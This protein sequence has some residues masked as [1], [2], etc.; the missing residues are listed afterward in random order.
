M[1]A[2]TNDNSILES[3]ADLIAHL[4]TGVKPRSDW[5][6]G[7]EHEKFAFHTEDLRPLSYDEPGG[8]RDLLNQMQAFGWEPVTES[9]N[10]IGL[11]QNGA[12]ISLEPGG[13]FELSGAPLTSIHETCDE[14]SSHL[15]QVRK[16][17]EDLQ[18]GFLGMGFHPTLRREDVPIMP[19]GRYGIMRAYMPTKGDMGLDMMLRTCTVQVNL[20]FESEADM[21]EKFRIGL[22]LQPI[23]TA[24]FAS[25]PFK[26]GKPNGFS[27]LRSHAW[28]R[29]D[30]DRTGMVPFVFDDD[31]GFE[32]YVDYVLDVPMY[33][34]VRD[35]QYVNVA[36]RS[37]R[38]FLR[39]EL[40]GHIG[41]KPTLADWKDHLSTVFTEVRLKT[42]L[43]MRGADGGPWS[44]LCGLPAVLG[45]LLND[46]PAQQKASAQIAAW[47]VE[48]QEALRAEVSK[49]GLKAE[50][51][52]APLYQIAR[53]VV[54]I[55]DEGLGR[56][57][58][59]NS[60]GE[61][62][63]GFLKVLWDSVQSGDNAA[64]RM[65]ALY[66]REWGEDVRHIFRDFAY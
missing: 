35:G 19:K 62:E 6:I 17:G 61:S 26:E 39:G 59:K 36:G 13:Q 40:P 58:M 38:D 4:E 31:F 55:S 21:V 2:P 8:I 16:I 3:K 20:D 27:S 60:M 15:E 63:Q 9:G 50:F 33:F 34:I 43:E 56:R 57:A 42:F 45:G 54:R 48:E 41:E 32:R 29:T 51:R 23:S 10:I 46:P 22:A 44:R 7:T 28:T 52:G 12:S 65:L 1:V 14:V 11:K 53:E 18:I 47:R 66:H 49:H 64:D 25:S 24:L 37:F 30:N 5:R